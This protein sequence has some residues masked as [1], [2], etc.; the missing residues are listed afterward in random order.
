MINNF[1]IGKEVQIL[2]NLLLNRAD[3]GVIKYIEIDNT[4]P[5]ITWLYVRARDEELNNMTDPKFPWSYFRI[6][7]STSPYLFDMDSEELKEI[8]TTT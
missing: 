7:E 4:S 3:I 2:D 1:F 5:E 6:I 8:I